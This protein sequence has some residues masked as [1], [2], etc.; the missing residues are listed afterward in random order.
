MILFINYNK[1]SSDLHENEMS[2]IGNKDVSIEA[3]G[4]S[5]KSPNKNFKLK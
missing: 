1:A 4:S 3:V 2:K 5:E